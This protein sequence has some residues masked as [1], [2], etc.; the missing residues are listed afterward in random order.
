MSFRLIWDPAARFYFYRLPIHSATL[1][2]RAVIRFAETGE[3]DLGWEA[4]YHVLRAG[5]HNALL[6]IDE[7]AEVISVLRIYRVRS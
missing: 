1:V 5:F 7:K 4:P 6:T 3:G 2:A